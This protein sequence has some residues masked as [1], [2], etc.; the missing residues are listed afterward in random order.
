M[1]RGSAKESTVFGFY[2]TQ[3]WVEGKQCPE[4]NAED[5]DN[6]RPVTEIMFIAPIKAGRVLVRAKLADG[7]DGL[8]PMFDNSHRGIEP[9]HSEVC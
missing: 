8:I 7:Y 5:F 3:R 2:C 4:G 6:V 9:V 1:Q